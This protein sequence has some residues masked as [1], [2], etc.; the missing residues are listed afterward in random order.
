MAWTPSCKC[1]RE[2]DGVFIDT[3][4]WGYIHLASTIGL[5]PTL[6]GLLSHTYLHTAT[7]VLW[8]IKRYT[9]DLCY[10]PTRAYTYNWQSQFHGRTSFHN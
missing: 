9:S 10:W 2:K 5:I 6:N 7:I 3:S 1:A 8:P 4:T